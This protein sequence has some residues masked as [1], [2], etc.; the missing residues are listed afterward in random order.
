M[1]GGRIHFRDQQTGGPYALKSFQK[2]SGPA[3]A[4]LFFFYSPRHCIK[5][6][7]RH[8]LAAL[9]CF[10]F[11]KLF[12]PL[13]GPYSNIIC[14]FLHVFNASPLLCFR[15]PSHTSTPF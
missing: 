7:L 8:T 13:W 3:A 15:I 6:E 9:F 14:F 4:L 10:F 12:C 1:T 11:P 5:Y 2:K